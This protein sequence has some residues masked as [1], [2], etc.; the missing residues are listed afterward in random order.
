[1]GG[2]GRRISEFEARLVYRMSSMTARATQKNPVLKNQ[3]NNQPTN[4]QTN[5]QTKKPKE[6]PPPKSPLAVMYFN[7]EHS[8][9]ELN[10][11]NIRPQSSHLLMK[12]Y[13]VRRSSL[14]LNSKINVPSKR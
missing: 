11:I 8:H 1:L 14:T 7:I 4:Q 3:P 6:P 10:V 12:D 5:K 13:S 9:A 2:R